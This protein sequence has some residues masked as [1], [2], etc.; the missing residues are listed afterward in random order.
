MNSIKEF[1]PPIEAYQTHLL[2]ASP[3]H[4]LY[5]E[6]CGNPKGQA[7]LFLHGGPGGGLSP[8]HRRYFD[9]NHYRIILFD[10]RGCGQST[11]HAELTENTT[12]DLVADIEKIRGLLNIQKWLVFGGSWGS[13]LA[14]AYAVTHTQNVLG[15]ILRGIFMCRPSEIRW[16]YQEGASHVFPEYWEKYSELIPENERQDYLRAY[17]RRLTGADE[18]LKLKAAQTWSQWEMATSYLRLNRTAVESMEEPHRALAFARIEAHYFVNNAFFESDSY[19]LD[20]I[21]KIAHL[22]GRIV[23]GRYDMVCPARSAWELHKKWKASE[24]NIIDDAGHSASEIGI[25]SALI[26]ATDQFRILR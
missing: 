19:L 5:I 22:P 9:P 6:E 2:K 17:H 16:F 12:W 21:A 25:R 3:L 4:T 10:Q 26:D 11:P 23:Q 7:I 14:L 24:L 8:D 18:K 15:L 20:Q 1:Y 13:T